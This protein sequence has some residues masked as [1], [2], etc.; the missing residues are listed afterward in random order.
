MLY[1]M[2]I[3]ILIKHI[4]LLLNGM[5]LSH[6]HWGDFIEVILRFIF[7]HTGLTIT[8]LPVVHAHIRKDSYYGHL[9]GYL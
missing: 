8:L 4:L 5:Q 1:F 7:F 3:H 9:L 2:E 6:A